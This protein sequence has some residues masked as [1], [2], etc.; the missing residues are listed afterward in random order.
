MAT[1]SKKY[2]KLLSELEL[3]CRR[4][5]SNDEAVAIIENNIP[6]T[7]CP[8]TVF[9]DLL[10]TFHSDL[11]KKFSQSLQPSKNT[12]PAKASI[13]HTQ[14]S[15][16]YSVYPETEDY[17]QRCWEFI[18]YIDKRNNLYLEQVIATPRAIIQPQE[19]AHSS[20]IMFAPTLPT[21]FHANT[22]IRQLIDVV[23][24][25]KFPEKQKPK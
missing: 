7:L 4:A 20:K 15:T 22:F 21:R 1:I 14:T 19:D 25:L 10:K 8:E 2:L 24:L 5:N 11:P 9:Q 13:S 17:K 6:D 18:F 23:W 12:K 3:L 16:I